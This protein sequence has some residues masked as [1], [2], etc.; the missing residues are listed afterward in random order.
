[1][2]IYDNNI[3]LL[4]SMVLLQSILPFLF[5]LQDSFFFG[6]LIFGLFDNYIILLQ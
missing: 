3:L 4:V 2:E 1:M 6:I 5:H